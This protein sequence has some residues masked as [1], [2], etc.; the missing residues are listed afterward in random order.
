MS[1]CLSHYGRAMEDGMVRLFYNYGLLVG[2]HPKYFLWGSIIFTLMCLPGFARLDMN[3]DLYKLFVPTDAPVRIEFE[4]QQEFNRIPAGD[5]GDG[6]VPTTTQ[7]PP[8]SKREAGEEW[9]WDLDNF[10]FGPGSIKKASARIQRA[11]DFSQLN[12]I[13]KLNFT[14]HHSEASLRSRRDI[15][16][17]APKRKTNAGKKKRQ[18]RAKNDAT[19]HGLKNDILR[20]YVIHK[21]FDN[22]L[23]SKYLGLL[24]K[25]TNEM[26]S[27][28][29]MSGEEKFDLEDFCR[30][31]A[32]DTKCNNNLNVWLKHAD[33]LFKDGKIRNNPN[34][35]LSYPVMYLF[36]RPKD[37]GNVIYG[38]D[39]VGEKNEIIGARV[40]TIHWF[41]TFPN[42]PKYNDAYSI[43]RDKLNEF[44]S[45][46]EEES[47]FTF[48][49]HNERA[50]DDEMLKIIWAVVPYAFPSTVCLTLF[51]IFAN[52]ST[53]IRKNKPLEM[54]MGVW[55]IIF[56]LIQ[57]FGIFFA[58]GVKFNPVT[59]TMPFL[60]LAIGV[61][62]DFL[63]M[64]AWR[65]LDP[66]MSVRRRVALVMADAGASI[67]F[68]SFTNFF[69]FG[70]GYYLCS[71]PA[72]AEFCL[73][74]SVGVIFDY[75]MQIT[76]FAA[77]ITL[78][79]RNEKHG[80]LSMCCYTRCGCCCPCILPK[81]IEA[82][83][84][85]SQ[86]CSDD[87]VDSD[88]ID[89]NHHAKAANIPYMHRWFRD[90][91]APFILRKDVKVASWA[92]FA[93]YAALGMY[94]CCI[95]RVDISPVKYIR[96]NSPIQTFVRLADKYIWADNVMPSFHVMNPPDLRDATQRAKFNEL[97]FRL[98]HTNYSIGRVSTNLWIWEYQNY[99]NDFPE[100]GYNE[101][102]S[103][104]HMKN[105]FNQMDYVQYR[106]K[107][108]I[109]SNAT[110]NEPCITAFSFQTSFYGLNSWDKRQSELFHWREII[111]EY[112][113]F[114]IFLAG[115]FSPFLIDQRRTIAPSTM[116]TVGCALL[117]MQIIC[118]FFLP[119]AQS[120]F[121]MTWSL[122]SISMG[123]CGGLALAGSDLDS[124]SMGC[125]VM[126]IGLA[127]DYS[128]HI[129]YRY[130]RSEVRRA[131][132]KV[133]DT[134]ASVAWPIMQAVG[135][136]LSATVC[137]IVV[138][139]YLIRVF[140]QTV[141]LV[142]IIGLF[143]GLVLLPQMISMLDPDLE[144]ETVKEDT[145]KA[146][147]PRM[148]NIK[149]FSGSSHPELAARI[150]DRLQLDVSKAS[151]KKFS[152]RE[153][154]VEI[155]ESVRGEDVFII[156]SACGE[157]NDN[158]MELLIMIN[159]CKIASSSRV[160]AVIP[161]FPY[162]RQD[163]KDKSRAPISAKLVANM[164][165]VAGADHII[166][167]DLHA[168]QIQ[169][170]FDI[171]SSVIVSPDAG[172]AKRVTSM[173]DRLN[174]EF[175]LIHKERKRANEVEKMTLVGNVAE[176]VAILVDDMADTCGTICL[177]AD[178]LVEA[179]AD[180]VYAFCVH[181]IFSGPALQRLNNSAFEAVVVTNTI[182]QEENMKKCPKIQ[183]IDISMILA[184]AIRRTHNGES[185][186]YLFS[187]V[188]IC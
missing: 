46:K 148:P 30:K 27:T 125:I 171:P 149:I 128:I 77:V 32:K 21:D 152:N 29:A 49:A 116:Q 156:Q 58:C 188:P 59:S 154:N 9:S 76:F 185:V 10:S 52:W 144:T 174:V 3:L 113:E 65:E 182:P 172:G 157:I 20:F 62:D 55:C 132:E 173:A 85:E 181:G 184:E 53:N 134:L 90:V 35:Q 40:L 78:S 54:C 121:I 33:T 18:Q 60:I 37:I 28:T 91:Y 89:P 11:T 4:R 186:S 109:N 19:V 117:V 120:V 119:D 176:K 137:L 126:A 100:I 84:A 97:V 158:L 15:V 93:I 147:K 163:K 106:D 178:K 48:V 64:A 61:D 70:L 107:V 187:H 151:L 169:G 7:A 26:M 86:E 108:K 41:I 104:E 115:I 23:Q 71:T 168:S 145:D 130:H 143:H 160:A 167:M 69:C 66:K 123:V 161:C 110:G 87:S 39:V 183:C 142:N 82:G 170:F 136:T 98:E 72:V 135:S 8:R 42:T 105:F 25:Y 162:A 164:L 2:K 165:S 129:C 99:L 12:D 51:V 67:T 80:G 159:A 138:P 180:K 45:S 88:D 24:W 75:I 14:G 95:L 50:M 146:N 102:Y 133:K 56:A 57:T 6:V 127:V 81:A 17:P 122:L 111:S 103:K 118:F 31:E 5:F 101:F 150:C 1:S 79:G 140:F 74:T 36:N 44:W 94:G 112:P 43:F 166:T 34:L 92:I 47:G 96:D 38:V 68:T 63:M 22:L 141:W 83:G 114:D 131:D 13:H 124:V 155:G 139:A 179:G 177:A 73:I 153:T 175:A 16:D